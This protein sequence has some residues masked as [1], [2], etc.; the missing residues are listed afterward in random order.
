MLSQLGTSFPSAGLRVVPQ[1]SHISFVQPSKTDLHVSIVN[2]PKASLHLK[3]INV[4]LNFP[5]YRRLL[6]WRTR[7]RMVDKGAALFAMA[8]FSDGSRSI[9][10]D[11]REDIVDDEDST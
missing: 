11:D 5:S 4:D 1:V 3:D 6:A 2:S 9:T 7:N 10:S 8:K